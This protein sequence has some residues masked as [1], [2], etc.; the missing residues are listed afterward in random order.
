M[1]NGQGEKGEEFGRKKEDGCTEGRKRWS[2]KS[3]QRRGKLTKRER[4][5]AGCL[6]GGGMGVVVCVAGPAVVGGQVDPQPEAKKRRKQ[7][8]E[9]QR[10]V[11][12]AGAGAWCVSGVWFGLQGLALATALPGEREKV[13]SPDFRSP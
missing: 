8:V 11:W 1:K 12:L 3:K 6:R 4:A 9:S 2:A 5:K 7:E 13:T 10:K